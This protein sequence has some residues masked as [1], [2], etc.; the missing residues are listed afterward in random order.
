M[1]NIFTRLIN[2]EKQLIA[3][4]NRTSKRANINEDNIN[5]NAHELLQTE[6]NLVEAVVDEF[7]AIVGEDE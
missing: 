4:S 5:T 7:N 3:L 1:A 2:V 6:A